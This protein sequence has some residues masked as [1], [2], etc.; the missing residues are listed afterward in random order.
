[1]VKKIFLH[2]WQSRDQ[3][4][5]YFITGSSG[6]ILDMSSLYVL[7]EFFFLS[8]V[9]AVA[10]NQLMMTAYLFLLNKY[11]AFKA[12]GISHQQLIRFIIIMSANYLLAVIWMW[13]W[14]HFLGFNYLVVRIVNIMLCVFWNFLLYKFWVF[15]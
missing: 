15:K 8:P 10:S 2:F 6:V 3:F 7:K 1:M 5:R 11:W 9:V 14:N 12:S 4:I 13:F